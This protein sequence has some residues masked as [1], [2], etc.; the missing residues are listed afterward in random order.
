[1]TERPLILFGNPSIAEKAKRYGGAPSLGIPDHNRQVERLVPQ[2]NALQNNINR[3][4]TFFKKFATD[5]E[6]EYTLVFETVG[7]PQNFYTA[8]KNL[9]ADY[10]AIEWL[11]ELSD[12]STDNSDDFYVRNSNEERD[13]SKQLTTKL[14]C[15]LSDKA[16][17][18]QMLSLWKNYAQNKNYAFPRG[19]TGFR[20][21]FKHLKD[22]HKWGV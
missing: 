11:M 16:A 6:P 18:E 21:V 7:D 12:D 22:I 2:F 14:F 17:L 13:D 1:M 4:G 20:E 9:K 19:L 15:V 10:P 8:V 5:T 3:G